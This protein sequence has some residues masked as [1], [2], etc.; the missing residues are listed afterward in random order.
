MT[1]GI[2]MLDVFKE[3]KD[4]VFWLCWNHEVQDIKRLLVKLILD[5]PKGHQHSVE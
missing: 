2:G 1:S 4:S 5:N 3:V